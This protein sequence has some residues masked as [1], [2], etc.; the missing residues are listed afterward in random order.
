MSHL[1]NVHVLIASCS[2]GAFRQP[3]R[4]RPVAGGLVFVAHEQQELFNTLGNSPHTSLKI[5]RPKPQQHH[6]VP[7]RPCRTRPGW[8]CFNGIRTTDSRTTALRSR[9]CPSGVSRRVVEGRR[10]A[11]DYVCH[12]ARSVFP[13]EHREGQ[14]PLAVPGRCR[15]QLRRECRGG[16]ESGHVHEEQ[17]RA[18]G[19]Q[20]DTGLSEGYGHRHDSPNEG[21]GG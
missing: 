17:D 16:D 11:G 21:E 6:A 8:G 3:F 2:S 19:E 20:A 1:R 4:S 5:Y 10:A 15:A 14:A 9:D 18:Q 12:A 13:W 7:R